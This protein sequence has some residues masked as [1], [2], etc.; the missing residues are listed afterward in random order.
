MAP[1][2]LTQVHWQF[3]RFGHV[4]IARGMQRTKLSR[5]PAVSPGRWVHLASTISRE[6]GLGVSRVNGRKTDEFLNPAGLSIAPGACRLG[7]WAAGSAPPGHDT[8]RTLR[9]RVD[10]LVIW[11]RVLTG[12]EIDQLIAAGRPSALWPD[13]SVASEAIEWGPGE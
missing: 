8:I 6:T 1:F 11:N 7:D 13:S 4:R 12:Q 9:G 5:E 2:F 10:E 3:N